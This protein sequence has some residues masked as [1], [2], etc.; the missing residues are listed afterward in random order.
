MD[1]WLSWML[2]DELG[3]LDEMKDELVELLSWRI[4]WVSW[5]S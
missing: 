2:K 5:M 1:E 4:S 3:K